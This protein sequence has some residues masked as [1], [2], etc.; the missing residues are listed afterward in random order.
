LLS[1]SHGIPSPLAQLVEEVAPAIAVAL[2]AAAARCL[3]HQLARLD[4]D[5]GMLDEL[6]MD[7]ILEVAVPGSALLAEA[8]TVAET[9][10]LLRVR[11]AELAPV[12]QLLEQRPLRPLE[13]L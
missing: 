1:I 11:L 4:E 7:E 5:L 8:K 13:L 2:E 3:E 10:Q 9:R 12:A 6:V